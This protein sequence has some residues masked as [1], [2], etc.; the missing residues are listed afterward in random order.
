[1]YVF[2]PGQSSIEISTLRHENGFGIGSVLPRKMRGRSF[3]YLYLINQTV[4]CD[5]F[6]EKSLIRHRECHEYHIQ[7]GKKEK[8]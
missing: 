7:I 4:L 6:Q 2:Y 5:E 8:S 1:M 3:R